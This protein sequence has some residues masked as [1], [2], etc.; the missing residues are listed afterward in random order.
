MPHKKI[1]KNQSQIYNLNNF[2][3]IYSSGETDCLQARMDR[4]VA[5]VLTA[6]IVESGFPAVHVRSELR[7]T[8]IRGKP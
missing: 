6:Q 8:N 2:I 3:Y 1:A 5:V 7:S 4:R